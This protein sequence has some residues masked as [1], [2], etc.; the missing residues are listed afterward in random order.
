MVLTNCLNISCRVW[1]GSS[2][3]FYYVCMIVW[4]YL[5]S[6]SFMCRSFLLFTL[7]FDTEMPHKIQSNTPPVGFNN[8]SCQHL[9]RSESKLDCR[10]AGWAI[11]AALSGACVSQNKKRENI[12]SLAQAFSRS[13]QPYSAI[14]WP[15]TS[16]ISHKSSQCHS[17]VHTSAL[18][19]WYG[20]RGIRST[21]VAT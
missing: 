15:E 17:I 9:H 5:L 2:I 4:S 11:K 16:S 12:V 20:R 10:S 13:I 21:V 14:K 7:V 3:Y 18:N 19:D 6:I 8:C 1:Y